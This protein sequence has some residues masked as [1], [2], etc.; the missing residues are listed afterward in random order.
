ML[1]LLFIVF[2]PLICM[3]YLGSKDPLLMIFLQIFCYCM[4]MKVELKHDV[5]FNTNMSIA[6][7][8]EIIGLILLTLKNKQK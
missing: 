3:W 5:V 1:Y 4:V 7:V 2:A 6:F 8:A